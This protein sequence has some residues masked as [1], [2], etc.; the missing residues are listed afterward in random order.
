[1]RLIDTKPGELKAKLTKYLS[2]D[3]KYKAVFEYTK[4][5]LMRLVIY[6]HITGHTLIGI[7]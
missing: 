1:M 3:S 7:L 4:S 2:E 6:L 5:D